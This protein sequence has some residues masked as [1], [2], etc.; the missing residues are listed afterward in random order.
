[1]NMKTKICNYLFSAV[2]MGI[3]MLMTACVAKDDNV[4]AA[5]DPDTIED[6]DMP[7]QA[8]TTDAL[9]VPIDGTTYVFDG[10]YS[11]EGKALVDRVKDRVTWLAESETTPPNESVENIILHNSQVGHLSNGEL[12]SIIMVMSKG[13]SIVVADP[14]IEKLE[15]LVKDLRTI[16]TFYQQA[17]NNRTARYVIQ[18]LNTET[19]NRIMM[20]T[21]GFDFS[22]YLDEEGKGD[23]MSKRTLLLTG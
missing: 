8:P 4:A 22:V 9:A 21:S 3:A 11:G 14:T 17:G 18:M 10:N 13:G 16:I 19:L 12:A 7:E 23:Y 2:L 15:K 5:G 20:W 6:F 1:M